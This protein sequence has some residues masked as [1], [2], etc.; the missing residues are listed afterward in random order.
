MSEIGQYEGTNSPPR[1]CPTSRR[2]TDPAKVERIGLRD[3]ASSSILTGTLTHRLPL[4][5]ASRQLP[6]REM[7][8]KPRRSQELLQRFRGLQRAELLLKRHK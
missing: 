4:F 1:Q 8:Q 5:Q 3:S 6:P 7:L 2:T